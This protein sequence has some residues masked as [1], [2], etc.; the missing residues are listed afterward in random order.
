MNDMCFTRCLI[1]QISEKGKYKILWCSTK[2][3]VEFGGLI[4]ANLFVYVDLK[5][6]DEK[7]S[8]KTPDFL[9]VGKIICV[10]GKTVHEV[11]DGVLSFNLL[12]QNKRRIDYGRNSFEVKVKLFDI[13]IEK[14]ISINN[15]RTNRKEVLAKYYNTEDNPRE[16]VVSL[17]PQ[18]E[19]IPNT[20]YNLS[21]VF[22]VRKAQ[23]I[24]PLIVANTFV[25]DVMITEDIY[26]K[27]LDEGG[28]KNEKK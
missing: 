9:S 4:D 6:F 2:V 24:I 26:I 22:F 21:G 5:T 7:N 12:V 14:V 3:P 19:L 25:K 10:T 20:S 13:S 16:I 27:D 17:S 23:Q 11:K 15:T 1:R 18:R 8:S 28:Q